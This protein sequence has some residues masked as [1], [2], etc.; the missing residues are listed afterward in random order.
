LKISLD[1]AISTWRFF[2]FGAMSF[3]AYRMAR[4]NAHLPVDKFLKALIRDVAVELFLWYRGISTM[5][6]AP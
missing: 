6:S 2:L 3:R 5:F 4:R 1:T